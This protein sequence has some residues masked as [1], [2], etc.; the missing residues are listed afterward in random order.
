M[1]E[2]K[3][4]ATLTMNWL[5]MN[6]PTL[7][8]I[9]GLV[10]YTAQNDAQQEA[11]IDAI[12]KS[13]QERSKEADGKFAAI[14][15]SVSVLSQRVEPMTNVVYRVGVVESQVVETNK[16]LDRLQEVL[17][18]S[19]EALRKDV[20]TMSTRVEVLAQKIDAITPIKR[21]GLE[22]PPPELR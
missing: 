6:V 22:A 18:A 17:L 20:N 8:A 16:R 12:E 21:A 19:I 7:L 5:R 10:W 1:N 13:R 4:D 15:T 2:M 14:N 9:G 11:R 3:S